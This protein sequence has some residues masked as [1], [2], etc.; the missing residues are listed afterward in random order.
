MNFIND[1]KK[2]LRGADL[3]KTHLYQQSGFTTGSDFLY[4]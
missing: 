1:F 4:G 2:D 3:M